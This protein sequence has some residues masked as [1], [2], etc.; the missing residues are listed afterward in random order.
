[1]ARKARVRSRISFEIAA[2]A[3]A[4]PQPGEADA[5]VPAYRVE[6]QRSAERD[7]ER[8]S[9]DLFGRI[10]KGLDALSEAPRPP[11]WEK[12]TGIE[13]YRIRVGDHRV[14]YEVDDK[15]RVVRVTRVR[16]RREVYR[17]LR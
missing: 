15:A 4:R 8:L 12:L 11:G 7:L 10:T 16:H 14:I 13:A 5:H 1:V 6:V 17:K 2:R 9:T 3:D